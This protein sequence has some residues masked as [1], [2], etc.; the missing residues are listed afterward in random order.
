M[1]MEN[2]PQK[3]NKGYRF[4]QFLRGRRYSLAKIITG[5]FLAIVSLFLL[6]VVV[7]SYRFH[8]VQSLLSHITEE[9]FPEMNYS[10]VIHNQVNELL[11]F[12]SHLIGANTQVGL[13][14]TKDKI[15]RKIESIRQQVINH[16]D[17]NANELE[18]LQTINN[19]L[20]NLHDLVKQK[21]ERQELII[22]DQ[23]K[24]YLLHEAV[25]KLLKNISSS[26]GNSSLT[27]DWVLTYS[28][29]ITL[30]SK[31]LIK[32]RLQ[33]VRQTLLLVQRKIDLL[34]KE[35]I[36]LPKEN[37]AIAMSL[38]NQLQQLLLEDDGLLLLKI[39]QLR[40]VGRLVGRDNFV[41]NLIDDF[42]RETEFRSYQIKTS[43]IEETHAIVTHGKRDLRLISIISLL[44]FLVLFFVIAFIQKWFVKRIVVLNK[45]V[46]ARLYGR[47]TKIE[48]GGNDEISD[49]ANAF[50]FFARKIEQQKHTLEA[51]SLTDGLTGL[52]NRRALDQRL[53]Y[54]LK[55]ATRH[56][57][58]EAVMLIDLDFF[59]KYNDTYGHI[60]GDSCLQAVSQALSRKLRRSIDFVARYGGE[61][62]IFLL[63]NTDL[64]G[65]QKV[66]N[67]IIK[68]IALL[69]IEHRT[70]EVASYVTLSI[71]IAI[72][73]P[74]EKRTTQRLL[75]DADNALY[76]AK[77]NGRNCWAVY[78]EK[79]DN[80]KK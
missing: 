4:F 27:A 16:D 62:F 33:E 80:S 9:S 65:A 8:T 75:E 5:G 1:D 40:I 24:L 35:L 47:Q 39:E 69:Q 55:A 12:S 45:N 6:V 78:Q 29:V 60:A 14:I 52:A 46:V 25:F 56:G 64:A 74:P 53:A 23:N 76:E 57:W 67:I 37:Q 44:I 73:T 70:S 31:G 36:D 61:E 20:D 43:L 22:A 34:K 3:G 79:T 19:E 68:Q 26:I 71:G 18:Q 28:E 11:Y 42:S 59:K 66:A 7:F 30:T 32:Q 17:N 63:P 10:N 38:T 2:Q 48:V 50:D 58:S 77:S 54:D 15:D 41:K 13:R 51:L 49:I 21:R 72:F